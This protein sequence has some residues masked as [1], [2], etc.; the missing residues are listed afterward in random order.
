MKVIEN[1]LVVGRSIGDN[2]VYVIQN[3]NTGTTITLHSSNDMGLELGM[4]GAVIYNGQQI[5][6][7][8]PALVEELA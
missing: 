3:E 2:N 7:F 5:V 6:S 1:A 8:E 4:E